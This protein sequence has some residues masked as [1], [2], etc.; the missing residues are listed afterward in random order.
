MIFS[1]NVFL[2]NFGSN[3]LILLNQFYV[4]IRVFFIFNTLEIIL[5]TFDSYTNLYVAYYYWKIQH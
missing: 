1:R 2:F 4:K 3:N 5:H